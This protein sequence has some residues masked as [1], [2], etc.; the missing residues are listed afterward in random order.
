MIF[1]VGFPSRCGAGCA[2]TL[3]RD[4]ASRSVRPPAR[5][6]FPLWGRIAA[7]ARPFSLTLALHV[8][9]G[10]LWGPQRLQGDLPAAVWSRAQ[11]LGTSRPDSQ[12]P[13][14]T[15]GG[16]RGRLLPTPSPWPHAWGDSSA[17][18]ERAQSGAHSHNVTG[19][20]SH[21]LQPPGCCQPCPPSPPPPPLRTPQS[22]GRSCH[23]CG[24]RGH[25]PAQAG[26]E[27]APPNPQADGHPS[28]PS[29][30][31]AVPAVLVQRARRAE[32][33][34]GQGAVPGLCLRLPWL[35]R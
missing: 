20:Q 4:A 10:P 23:T 18:P 29:C 21:L 14:L 5:A 26:E 1:Q 24:P 16:E 27:A 6:P 8:V 31:P 7:C 32:G 34:D 33:L 12:T 2:Q 9:L 17:A 13:R 28:A 25:P 35:L 19:T 3:S 30:S 11:L 15:P 22:R